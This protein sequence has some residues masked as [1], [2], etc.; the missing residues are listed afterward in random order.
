MPYQ[1]LASSEFEGKS[2]EDI[3][4]RGLWE[5]LKESTTAHGIPHVETSR[6]KANL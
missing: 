2:R 3:P 6:G 5:G 4:F 1:Y